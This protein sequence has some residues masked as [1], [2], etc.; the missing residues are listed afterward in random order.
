MPTQHVM[1]KEEEGRETQVLVQED[2]THVILQQ[3][4]EGTWG[5]V[6]YEQPEEGKGL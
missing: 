2:G 5:Q 1:L 4:P 3:Q 6:V